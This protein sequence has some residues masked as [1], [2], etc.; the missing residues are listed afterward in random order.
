MPWAHGWSA[1]SSCFDTTS[2]THGPLIRRAQTMFECTLQAAYMTGARD[3]V[4]GKTPYSRPYYE[5]S[6]HGLRRV[7]FRCMPLTQHHTLLNTRLGCRMADD[8]ENSSDP[9][10]PG[11]PSA[12]RPGA[13]GPWARPYHIN[14]R[15]VYPR[16]NYGDYWDQHWNSGVMLRLSL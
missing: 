14:G 10:P 1:R 13:F 3:A 7:S 9:Y 2:T 16:P 6:A 15:P 8:S 12:V 5:A 4:L 11:P